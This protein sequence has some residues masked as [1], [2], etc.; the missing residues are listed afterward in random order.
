MTQNDIGQ[1]TQQ[2]HIDRINAIA[3]EWEAGEL[4]YNA[5][6]SLLNA[7]LEE[8]TDAGFRQAAGQVHQVIGLIEGNRGMFQSAL[9]EFE[10][11]ERIFEECGYGRGRIIAISNQG[12]IFRHL[13]KY[14]RAREFFNQARQAAREIGAKRL[15]ANA[16]N[17]EGLIYLQMEANN[18]ARRLLEDAAEIAES[19]RD[20]DPRIER[21]LPETYHSLATIYLRDGEIEKAWDAASKALEISLA[22]PILMQAGM[23]HRTLAEIASH[24]DCPPNAKGNK[25][26]PS[27]HYAESRRYLEEIGA[28]G[29]L[30]HVWFSQGRYLAGQRRTW[31]ALVALRNALTIF[32]R[33]GMVEDAAKVAE[34]QTT[35][36]PT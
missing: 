18:R 23:A 5:A 17:N 13:G 12:E 19:I 16:L 15:E 2:E 36:L 22:V 26:N 7:I 31:G 30:G 27:H 29:E 21:T 20:E 1:R 34:E 33:L 14:A 28:E 25:P 32:T 8:I 10:R 9:I 24:P 6:L 11:A 35:L 3:N 4:D